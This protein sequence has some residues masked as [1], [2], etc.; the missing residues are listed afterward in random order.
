MLPESQIGRILKA[1]ALLFLSVDIG[2]IPTPDEPTVFSVDRLTVL[3][4]EQF[5]IGHQ[6]DEPRSHS[7]WRAGSVRMLAHK[8]PQASRG[9]DRDT[10]LQA[11]IARL[12]Q[13]E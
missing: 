2:G 10:L 13:H 11:Y 7:G 8:R 3:L 12:A 1:E 6:T 4:Q 5:A 9:L